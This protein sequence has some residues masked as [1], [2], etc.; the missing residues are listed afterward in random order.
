MLP[1]VH[2]VYEAT[3][4]R[5]I[6]GDTL[7]VHIAGWPQPFDPIDVRVYGVDTPE[8]SKPPAKK[9]CEVKKGKA[10]AGYAML[11][12]LPGDTVTITYTAGHNDKYGR[13]LGSVTLPNGDDWATRM[14]NAKYG[15][16]YG[17]NGSLTKAP[18]C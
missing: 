10:A 8:H 6:D 14:I 12:A 11:M 7:K 18:W 17:L 2:F 4:L 5:V 3:V 9:L 16:P 15:R 13:L 1:P